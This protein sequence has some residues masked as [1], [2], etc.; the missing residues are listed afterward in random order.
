MILLAIDPGV[1]HHGLALFEDRVL[2]RCA[3][4]RG[5]AG[6][7]ALAVSA[8]LLARLTAEWADL[9]WRTRPCVVAELP[10]DR[11]QDRVPVGDLI[12]LT[13]VLGWTLGTIGR[14]AYL[15]SPADW[16]GSIPKSKHQPRII[17]ALSEAERAL[18]PTGALAHN[19]IDAVGIGLWALGR[20]SGG[21]KRGPFSQG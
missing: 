2:I 5:P 1:H 19:A 18:I 10:Q 12:S 21:R 15:I 16:K 9:H 14:P 11:S 4:V 8:S 3:G 6:K 20:I 13:C 17:A 7:D